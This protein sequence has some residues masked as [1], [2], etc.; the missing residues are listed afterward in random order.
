MSE[1]KLE[2]I[3]TKIDKLDNRLDSID[4]TLAK[5]HVVLEEHIKRTEILEKDVAPIKTHVAKV[6]GALKLVGILSL[7]AGILEGAVMLLEYM[8]NK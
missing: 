4:I 2:Q 7:I 6:E 5:Q 1:K 8:R 3:E